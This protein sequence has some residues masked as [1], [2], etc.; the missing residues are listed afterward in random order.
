MKI[1]TNQIIVALGSVSEF[2]DSEQG[3]VFRPGI[4]GITVVSGSGTATLPW[5][6]I[7]CVEHGAGEP[8]DWLGLEPEKKTKK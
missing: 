8:P 1:Y 3:T 2:D 6:T 4:Y 5:T 7:S